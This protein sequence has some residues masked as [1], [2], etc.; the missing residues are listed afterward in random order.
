MYDPRM[1]K[2]ARNLIRYCCRLKKGE[3]ILIET[4]DVP[5]EMTALVIR[6][7]SRVGGVVLVTT[8]HNR[9]LRELYRTAGR[10]GMSLAGEVERFRMEKVQAYIALRGSHNINELADVP[11]EKFILSDTP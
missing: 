3:K 6:E 1:Q 2:L 11:A 7:A 8:K 10:E 5:E 9:I 4:I